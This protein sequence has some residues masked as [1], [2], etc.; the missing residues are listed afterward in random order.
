MVS[1]MLRHFVGNIFVVAACTACKIATFVGKIFVARPSTTKTTNILPYENYPLYGKCTSMLTDLSSR[2]R[3]EVKKLRNIY[4]VE[5]ISLKK[6]DTM[7]ILHPNIIVHYITALN[8]SIIYTV[9]RVIFV[10]QNIRGFC[11]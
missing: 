9:E 3:C 6:S 11:D 7:Q 1:A 8:A 2:C 4:I 5:S 10:G